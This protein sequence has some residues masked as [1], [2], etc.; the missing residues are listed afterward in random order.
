MFK[1]GKNKGD[2]YCD[3]ELQNDTPKMEKRAA[4]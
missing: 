3:E 4:E 2:I 1:K